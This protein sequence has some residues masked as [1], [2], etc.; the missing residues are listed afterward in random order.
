MELL[1]LKSFGEF[2]ICL[3]VKERLD[4]LIPKEDPLVIDVLHGL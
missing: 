2:G 1:E 3:G 4:G